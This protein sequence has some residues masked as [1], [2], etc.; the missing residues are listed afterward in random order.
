[1]FI[2]ALWLLVIAYTSEGE[3]VSDAYVV[4]EFLH[5]EQCQMA[6]N[7]FIEGFKTNKELQASVADSGYDGVVMGC[8]EKTF[9]SEYKGL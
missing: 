2:K 9:D 5:E 7:V 3:I 8:K 6:S 1:M 4:D